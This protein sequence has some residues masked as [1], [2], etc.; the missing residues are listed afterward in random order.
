MPKQIA[1]FSNANATNH[2]DRKVLEL[3]MVLRKHAP[4]PVTF[5]TDCRKL[6]NSIVIISGHNSKFRAISKTNQVVFLA[7]SGVLGFKEVLLLPRID[8]IV[9]YTRT[10]AAQ[11]S[12]QIRSYGYNTKVVV[13]PPYCESLGRSIGLSETISY[14]K[15]DKKY[16]R[17]LTG[18]N[19]VKVEKI[20]P[21]RHD[22]F[23]H[24]HLTDSKDGWAYLA[25]EAMAAGIPPIINAHHPMSEYITHGFN[26]FLVK[27]LDDVVRALGDLK[28][29]RQIIS[30][31]CHK[32]AKALL[33]PI[34]YIEDFS[35]LDECEN[36]NTFGPIKIEHQDRKSII[37]EKTLRGR[38]QVYFPEVYDHS[39]QTIDLVE[40]IDILEYFSARL[41]ADVYVFGCELPEWYGSADI[42]HVNSLVSKLGNRAR[43]IH[44]CRDEAVPHQW[45]AAFQ[46]L[47]LISVEEG[48]KQISNKI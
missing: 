30:K 42:I 38:D 9:A 21:G 41:F 44:F 18:I 23:A 6:E 5:N 31:N 37:R 13:I 17:A 36:L 39:M 26:G 25:L 7:R 14:S 43:R 48:L 4:Y 12:W 16:R 2:H 32:T 29:R 3:M 33:S 19:C 1:I 15:L 8:V 28:L 24:V 35:N 22:I 47:S 27:K 20:K 40:I 45:A 34:R 11:L 10:E 46:K